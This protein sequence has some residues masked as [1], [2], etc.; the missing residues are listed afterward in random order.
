MTRAFVV[1]VIA[2]SS[3]GSSAL[4]ADRWDSG[5]KG[6]ITAGPTCPA[7]RYPPDPN[8]APRPVETTIKIKSLPERELV[9]KVHSG[10]NG[11]FRARLAPGRYRLVPQPTYELMRCFSKDVTVAKGSFAR[12]QL[13]CDT[14]IR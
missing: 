14:G 5:V 4:A 3:L 11:Y 2:A 13:G 12:V 6:R 9:K 8:C 10:E 1:A 7:E